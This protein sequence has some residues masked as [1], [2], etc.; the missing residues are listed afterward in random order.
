MGGRLPKGALTHTETAA[1]RSIQLYGWDSRTGTW[2]GPTG[3]APAGRASRR[4]LN[5]L[6]TMQGRSWFG[7]LQFASPGEPPARFFVTV[8]HLE[9]CAVA[10]VYCGDS[11]AGPAEVLAV[12]P[13]EFRSRLRPEFAFEFLAFAS[14]LG[15]IGES[16][17][18]TVQDRIAAAIEESSAADSMVF[19]LCTGLWPSDRDPV[20][21]QCIE[22]I[23]MSLLPWLA[24][25]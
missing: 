4:L 13:A 18:I 16:A 9:D 8:H 5:T 2:S 7:P 23:A 21:S 22:T 1:K 19:S 17:A 10:M 3:L 25:R 24:E 11:K 14:F 12:I 20:L 15:G 6:R